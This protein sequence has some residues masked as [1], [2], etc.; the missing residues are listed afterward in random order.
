M[1]EKET[2]NIENVERS[3]MGSY[4]CKEN[5]T[6]MLAFVGEIV[7]DRVLTITGQLHTVQ[8]SWYKRKDTELR[9]QR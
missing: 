1:L 9:D 3:E 4:K 5:E 7:I 6:N 8:S 2:T